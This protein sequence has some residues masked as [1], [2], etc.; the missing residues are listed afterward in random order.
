MKKFTPNVAIIVIVIVLISGAVAIYHSK[1]RTNFPSAALE[2][3]NSNPTL[4]ASAEY[5]SS[6]SGDFYYGPTGD[7]TTSAT[8]IPSPAPISDYIYD[9]AKIISESS[10]K[11]EIESDAN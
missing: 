6:T 2:T 5:E 4:A 1:Q 9:G 8:P 10:S 7:S 3:S 11:L